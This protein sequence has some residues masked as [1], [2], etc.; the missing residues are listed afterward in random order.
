[1]TTKQTETTAVT[2]APTEPVQKKPFSIS[3]AAPAYAAF[4]EAV[5]LAR[6]GY[7]FSDGPVIIAPDGMAFF[8]LILGNPNDYAIQAAKASMRL[9]ANEEEAQRKK[10]IEQAAKRLLEEQQRAKLEADVAAATKALEKQIADLQKAAA[11]E[12]AKLN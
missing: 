7:T 12:L 1:M 4:H 9:S 8:T 10:D 11:A 5:V 3:I 6:Q 2:P